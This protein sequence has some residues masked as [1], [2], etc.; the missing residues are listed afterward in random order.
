MPSAG[1][2]PQLQCISREHDVGRGSG[3]SADAERPFPVEMKKE[4]ESL[5]WCYDRYDT[6]RAMIAEEDAK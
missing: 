3:L 4:Q 6:A 5:P 1:Q 2:K